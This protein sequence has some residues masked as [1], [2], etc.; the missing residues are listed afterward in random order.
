M[1]R[2]TVNL[3]VVK[4]NM[5]GCYQLFETTFIFGINSFKKGLFDLEEASAM[6]FRKARNNLHN[7]TS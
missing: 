3:C 2:E 5:A 1:K 4:H 7:V 6:I